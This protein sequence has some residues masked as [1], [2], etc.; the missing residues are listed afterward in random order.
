VL[1]IPE[2]IYLQWYAEDGEE[3]GDITWCA[4]RIND[5]DIEYRRLIPFA[6]DAVGSVDGDDQE[7]AVAQVRHGG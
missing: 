1:E 7:Q 3:S 5:T 6:P 4:D 2:V